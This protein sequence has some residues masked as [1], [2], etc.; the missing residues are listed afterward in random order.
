M[1]TIDQLLTEY[2]SEYIRTSGKE[3]FCCCYKSGWFRVGDTTRCRRAEFEK[4]LE[5][6]KSRPTV[7][8]RQEMVN[9]VLTWIEASQ[10][11]VKSYLA[12]HADIVEERDTPHCCSPSSETYWSM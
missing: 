1:K 8:R 11:V 10:H 12:P 3:L 4:M 5:T 2:K 9:G 6:L 7:T